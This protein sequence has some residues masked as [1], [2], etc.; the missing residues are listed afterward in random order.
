MD[1]KRANPMSGI[2]WPAHV[3][4]AARMRWRQTAGPCRQLAFDLG[5]FGSLVF[6]LVLPIGPAVLLLEFL[7]TSGGINELHLAGVEGMAG[8]TNFDVKFGHSAAGLESIA[9]TARDS[10]FDVIGMDIRLH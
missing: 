9:A 4:C 5:G 3:G 1:A 7:D 8:R 2:N 10:R 6:D